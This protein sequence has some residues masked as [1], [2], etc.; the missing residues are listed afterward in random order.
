M[1]APSGLDFER[2]IL[3]LERK[4][5]EL[6]TF[7]ETKGVDL[8]ET[9]EQLRAEQRRLAS[10]IYASLTPW[11]EVQVARHRDRPSTMDFIAMVFTQFIEL[12]GDR[13]FRDD[14]AIVCGFARLDGRRLLVI[15]HRKGKS[16]RES[17]ACNWGL[18]HPEGYRKAMHKARLA[19]RLGIP[20]VMFIDT[21]G[22]YPGV[23]A[24]ER[25]VAQ[26][27]A[28][29]IADLSTLRVPILCVILGEGASGGALGIGVGDRMLMLQHAYFSVIT[30]EGCAAILFRSSEK[31][32]EAA[33][34]LHLTSRDMVQ[35]GIADEVVPEPDLAAHYQPREAATCLKEAL[36]RHLGELAAAPIEELLAKRYDKYRRLGQFL[37]GDAHAAP[38]GPVPAP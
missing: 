19:E 35:F 3:D 24:E 13:L 4:I 1:S 36:I 33:A 23:G 38:P 32:E 31:K 20:I 28:E 21:A 27:I 5:Q 2:P 12:H 30:P 6:A 16:T 26:S 10:T 9:I 34:A 25:G 14:G 17:V 15:G 18:P 11:Q 8:S 37:G 7:Q 29:N 22:A